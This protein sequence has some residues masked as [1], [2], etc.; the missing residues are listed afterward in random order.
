MFGFVSQITKKLRREKQMDPYKV[1]GVSPSATDEEVK[2]AYRNLSKKYH[3]DANVNNPNQDEYEEKFKEVQAA[4]TAIMD[5]RQGKVPGGSD[6][7]GY[8]Q[9]TQGGAQSQSQSQD[10]QYMQAAVGYIQNGYYKE[11]LNPVGIMIEDADVRAVRG[12]TGYAKCGGNYAASNRAGERAAQKGYSQVLWLDGVERKY[13]EEV[14]AMNIFFKIDGKI[15]TPALS[16]SILPG[17]T[18]DSVLTYCRAKGIPCEER[19]IS[20]DELVEAQ[21]SGKLGEVFGSGTAAVISPVG[22]LRY[23]DEVFTIGDGT[24][25][26]YSQQLYDFITGV[27]T[28]KVEDEFG[29]RMKV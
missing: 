21:R 26:A 23:K 20:V 25:G 10:Q 28:G 18:R 27:Q 16:G 2:K 6:F 13:I 7:W 14:G 3:P 8:G 4:Y 29:W 22:K 12:G 19:R 15:V 24:I 1:L 11:G 17:I 9:Q 5:Q